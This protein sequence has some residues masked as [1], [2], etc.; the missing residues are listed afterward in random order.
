MLL[1]LSDVQ[2]TQGEKSESFPARITNAVAYAWVQRH[3]ISTSRVV[4]AACI[5]A[6]YR[7]T[8]AVYDNHLTDT[9]RCEIPVRQKL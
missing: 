8:A 5:V 6:G 1:C 2:G 7:E 9:R 3:T 4:A